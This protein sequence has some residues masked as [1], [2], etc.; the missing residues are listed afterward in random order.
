M[1]RAVWI[2]PVLVVFGVTALTS[3]VARTPVKDLAPL[4][5][6]FDA[7]NLHQA[8]VAIDEE[9]QA[10]WDAA[11]VAAA[12][13]ADDLVVLRRLSLA[14]HGT[15]PSLEELRLFERDRRPDRL[16]Y[17][18][19][20]MLEDRRFADYFAERLARG[21][22]GVEGGQF[23]IFRRDRF[24]SWLSSQIRQHAPYDEMVRRMITGEGVWT[25]QGEV[26]FITG[27]FA[28]GEFDPNQLTARTVRAFLG[29]RIDCA[30]CH[31]HP[32]DHWTQSQFEG[33]TAHYGQV[34][35]S[36]AGII[37]RPRQEYVVE[38]RV[39]LEKRTVA[40]DVP[41]HPEWQGD[42]GTRREK[43]ARWITHPENRRF[44]RA[45]ANRVWGLMFGKPFAR[46]RP[47]D[48]LPDPDADDSLRVLD[49]L[50][51][52]FRDHGYDLRR[53]IQVIAGTRAF[54]MQ[55][56]H[57]LDEEIV[58][59]ESQPDDQ[60]RPLDRVREHW[61]VF[62]LVRLRP[63]QVIGAMLQ[64]NNIRTIDQNSHLF[65]RARRFFQENDFVKA[66]GDPGVDELDERAGTIP[67]ALLR[68][69]G[70][71]AAELTKANPFF[72]PGRIAASSSTP[73]HVVKTVFLTCLTRP[74]TQEE[75]EFFKPWVEQ[76]KSRAEGVEDLYWTLLNSPEFS[77]NH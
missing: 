4:L 35:L 3:W 14:L 59:V 15:V 57:S 45:T 54:R 69:N 65:V 10:L 74:P 71:F 31:D 26:N 56:V 39:T 16:G 66:F 20:A 72:A 38:D 44:E 60:E 68:M 63:E 7:V 61:G 32:F 21:F 50:G 48:D 55:S 53:L 25:G 28:D 43:L 2:W 42:R 47:V 75:L 36:I 6:T 40:A 73:E 62:P 8:V 23:L 13:P 12:P 33:L 64:A 27:A 24:L 22:V 34:K 51:A 77:W 70:S 30:Q 67:Q 29:Q 18:I 5:T 11:G 58:T 46:Q 37:D 52:D 1:Q 49:L 9:M 41:F 76:Q 19:S 17:W